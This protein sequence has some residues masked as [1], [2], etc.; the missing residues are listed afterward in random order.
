MQ[1]M[2]IC[3]CDMGSDIFQIVSAHDT[4][5]ICYNSNLLLILIDTMVNGI[6]QVQNIVSP[7]VL[8]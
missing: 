7:N 4:Q 1:V 2:V 3:M 5:V 6:I 8:S